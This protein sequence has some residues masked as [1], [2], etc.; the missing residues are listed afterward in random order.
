MAFLKDKTRSTSDIRFGIN[1]EENETHLP[2]KDVQEVPLC[3]QTCLN[4]DVQVPFSGLS[5]VTP[6]ASCPPSRPFVFLAEMDVQETRSNRI[7]DVETAPT[8]SS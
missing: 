2:L 8:S 5:R 4:H 3:C 1:R 7:P 6:S